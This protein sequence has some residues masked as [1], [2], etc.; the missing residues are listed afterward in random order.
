VGREKVE[1][2]AVEGREVVVVVVGILVGRGRKKE[3]A[4]R[5]RLLLRRENVKSFMVSLRVA[6]CKSSVKYC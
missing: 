6:C 2:E 3:L 4:T 5:R 1:E